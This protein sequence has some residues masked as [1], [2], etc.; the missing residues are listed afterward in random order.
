ML[1]SSIVVH[2]V[3]VGYHSSPIKAFMGQNLELFY[4][5][6][7]KNVHTKG[8]LFS[9]LVLQVFILRLDELWNF[10][11]INLAFSGLNWIILLLHWLIFPLVINVQA[12]VAKLDTSLTIIGDKLELKLFGFNDKLSTLLSKIWTISRSFSPKADR[13]K[14]L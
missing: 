6:G 4:Q 12:G 11:Y 3:L 2:C 10:W 13:F 5:F 7:I 14:V 9:L 1:I 8:I